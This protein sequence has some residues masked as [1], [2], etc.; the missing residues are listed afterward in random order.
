[1]SRYPAPFPIWNSAGPEI[2]WGEPAGVKAALNG[3]IACIDGGFVS[4]NTTLSP[5]L[6][7]MHLYCRLLAEGPKAPPSPD[8]PAVIV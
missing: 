4:A 6:A 3:S 1:M 8:D 2:L 5:R 7:P